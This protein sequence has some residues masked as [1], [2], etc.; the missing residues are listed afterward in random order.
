MTKTFKGRAMLKKCLV[1]SELLDQGRIHYTKSLDPLIEAGLALRQG[2][3]V[4]LA[5]TAALREIVESQCLD[6]IQARDQAQELAQSLGLDVNIGSHPREAL[7]LLTDLEKNGQG[8]DATFR[9]QAVSAR[10]FGDSKHIQRTPILSKIFAHWSR[11]R[12]L[13]GELR[14]KACAPLIHR[15][16]KLDLGLV[17]SALGQVCI[18]GPRAAQVEDFDLTGIDFVLTSENMAPFQQIHPARGLVLFCPG[19]NTGLPAMWLRSMPQKCT[20]I[21]FGDFDPDGLRIFEQLCLQSGR[22]GRF[23][24]ELGHLQGIRESLPAWNGTRAFDPAQYIRPEI[25][26]LAGWGRNEQVYAEQEQILHL[27]GWEKLCSK[28]ELS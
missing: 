1:W 22:E 28:K 14:L 18:P 7:Q 4:V 16:W 9:V 25:R 17:T 5:D 2:R 26:D 20:W 27:L 23:V 13:G 12:H 11:E 24:P 3:E 19:Y 6:I 8:I 21:H 15:P 10:V